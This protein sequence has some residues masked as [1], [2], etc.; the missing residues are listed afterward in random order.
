LVTGAIPESI[1]PVVAGQVLEATWLP[2]PAAAGFLQT[3]LCR[4]AAE[5]LADTLA[6]YDALVV[7]CGI[8]ATQDSRAFIHALLAHPLPPMVLDADGLNALAGQTPDQ[9]PSLPGTV[10]TPHPAE[11]ARLTG[12]VTASAVAERWLLARTLATMTSSV[13][14]AKGP[15]TVIA[16]SSGAMGVLPIATPALATA[17]TGDVLSGLIGGLLAQGL[18]P[19]QA[20]C[21]GAWLHGQAGLLCEAELGVS[22]S[23]AGDIVERIGAAR[24]RLMA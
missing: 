24:K 13:V 21:C 16:T 14:L 3:T 1:W 2:L 8:G 23:V 15:Y 22:G 9:R 18:A 10:L 6:G 12:H 5:L 19:F 7:G 11:L 20:A 17:G 4:E